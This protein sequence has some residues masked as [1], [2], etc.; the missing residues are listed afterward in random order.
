LRKQAVLLTFFLV[1]SAAAGD[2]GTIT[3]FRL[4]DHHR[5]WKPVA[6]C[7]GQRIA[8]VQGGKY[9]KMNVAVGKHT[10]TSNNAKT[11]VDLEVKPGGDYF[12]RVSGTTGPFSENGLLEL[13]DPVQA[14][15][16]IDRLEALPADQINGVCRNP[17]SGQ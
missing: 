3:I 16:Q 7:D 9:I 17:S 2:V 11:G 13:A 8:A 5:G 15:Q 14:R 12:I 10:F 4:V 6:F 1:C